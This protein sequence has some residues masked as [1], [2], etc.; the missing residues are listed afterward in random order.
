MKNLKQWL[1]NDSQSGRKRTDEIL[2]KVSYKQA[3]KRVP[4]ICSSNDPADMADKNLRPSPHLQRKH[5]AT[6]SRHLIKTLV[7][8]NL[9][10]VYGSGN[11]RAYW[12]FCNA[13]LC[14]NCH[15]HSCNDRNGRRNVSWNGDLN[16]SWNGTCVGP[17]SSWKWKDRSSGVR[18][19][20]FFSYSKL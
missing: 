7:L 14:V 5:T 9:L 16:A 10:N 15:D 17:W 13:L 3:A 18:G 20:W 11:G 4:A 19:R 12:N 8:N 6:L 1:I 2:N